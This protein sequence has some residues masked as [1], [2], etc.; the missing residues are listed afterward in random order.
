MVSGLWLVPFRLAALAEMIQLR[1]YQQAA[2]DSIF[3]YFTAN[4]GNPLVVCPTGSGKSVI[5]GA[6]IET[7]FRYWPNQK[8]MLLTHVKELLEQNHDKLKTIWPS[9]PVGLYSAGLGRRDVMFPITVAGIQSVYKKADTFGWIDLIIID[10]AHLLAPNDDGMYRTFINDCKQYNKNLK[11]IGLTATPFRT[12]GGWL[13][14]GEKRIFTDICYNIDISYLIKEGHLA[15]IRSRH[16]D[17]QADLTGVHMTGGDYNQ[18][19]LQRAMD[20]EELTTKALDEVM[21]LAADRRSWLIFC[22][23]V[24]HAEHVKQAII[25]R[26]IA[27]EAVTGKTPQEERER[28][29]ADYKSGRLRALTS[30]GVLTTGF[31]APSTDLIVLLRATQSAGLYIQMLGRGMRTNPGKRDCLLLDYGGNVERFGPIN[32]IDVK[33][34][35]NRDPSLK[36]EP[37]TKVCPTCLTDVAAAARVCDECGHEFPFTPTPLKTH[38]AASG[39]IVADIEDGIQKMNVDR[40]EYERNHGKNGK[41]DTLKVSYLNG[42]KC[43][44]EFICIEHT[45]F[46]RGKAVAWWTERAGIGIAAPTS[47]G[48]AIALAPKLAIPS[49]IKIQKP[50]GEKYDRIVGYVGFKAPTG[51]EVYACDVGL[52]DP[53]TQKA[54]KS[55]NAAASA[56]AP[57]TT[58][59]SLLES[60]QEQALPEAD[61]PS[62]DDIM[63]F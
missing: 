55:S 11:I 43:Y 26:G 51:F 58:Q 23:G 3:R 32:M 27:C 16:T 6:F 38:T 63:P 40:I 25:K 50:Y 61:E 8:I 30:M 60:K 62:F 15:N 21:E 5:Q 48:D 31:D 56:A 4:K 35:P 54:D 53:N 34:P 49:V 1:D 10:E 44:C 36:G 14:Y 46:A 33:N 2:V 19:E 39:V 20:Q 9:A 47:I 13:N 18:G 17:T 42:R 28:I 37:V 12:Q 24:D 57:K 45:G 59:K 52:L 7:I 29:L 41:K 22:S